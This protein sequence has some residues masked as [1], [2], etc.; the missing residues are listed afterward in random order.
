MQRQIIYRCPRTGMNVQHQLDDAAL[1]RPAENIHVSVRCPA[2]ASMHF[3]NVVT[4]KLLGDR[5]GPP[6]HARHSA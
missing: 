1:E 4:G 6:A 3:V 5:S 2:C